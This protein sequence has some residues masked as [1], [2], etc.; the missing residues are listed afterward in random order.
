[1]IQGPE[2]VSEEFQAGRWTPLLQMG[3]AVLK[4]EASAPSGRFTALHLP[5]GI[6][7]P[8]RGDPGIL[9]YF[10]SYPICLKIV[11]VF[12]HGWIHSGT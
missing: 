12:L 5:L 7:L 8:G 2:T 10:I 3:S 9:K 11:V 4:L 1:M 6:P